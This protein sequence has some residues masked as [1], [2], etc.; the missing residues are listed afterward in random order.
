MQIQ[1]LPPHIFTSFDVVELVGVTPIYLNALV[2]RKL[3]G[4]KPSISGRGRKVRIFDEDDAYGIAFVWILFE[5]GLRTQEIRTILTHL[6]QT[7]RADAKYT[8]QGWLE[9]PA[10]EYLLVARD[11][12]QP[13]SKRLDVGRA[14]GYEI[15][16]I[17]K[18]NPMTSLLAIPIGTRFEEIKER[19]ESKYG[20]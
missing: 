20:G 4:I 17:L 13:K 7:R 3:Y 11:P 2:Q 12:S 6:T 8:A 15:A 14:H 10:G 19:I 16:N 5:S 9:T 1:R 18:E